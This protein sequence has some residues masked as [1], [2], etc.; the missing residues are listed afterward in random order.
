MSALALS[1]LR[2]WHYLLGCASAREQSSAKC[3][4]R[5]ALFLGC[6]SLEMELVVKKNQGYY[7]FFESIKFL[8]RPQVH[9]FV[10]TNTQTNNQTNRH[11]NFRDSS[12]GEGK[13]QML[14]TLPKKNQ[15]YWFF[16][17]IIK[18][19]KRPQVHSF[20]MTN[21]QTDKQTNIQTYKFQRQF[22]RGRKTTNVSHSA[23]WQ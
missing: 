18:F 14:A 5:V 10:M 19:F 12:V 7:F 22:R 23:E 13:Q 16:F 1:A 9:S 20:V 21:K 15:G 2:V 4:T 3:T 6:A 8:K 17:E 11:T